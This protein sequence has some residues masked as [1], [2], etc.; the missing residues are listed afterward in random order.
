MSSQMKYVHS[1]HH[2]TPYPWPNSSLQDGRFVYMQTLIDW[3]ER[4]LVETSN[5][6]PKKTR[7]RI[8]S[9]VDLSG[10]EA[11]ER[12]M[13]GDSTG[14]TNG[15]PRSA[16]GK[17]AFPLEVEKPSDTEIQEA[18]SGVPEVDMD[19]PSS[20]PSHRND[21]RS[22]SFSGSIGKIDALRCSLSNKKI[23]CVHLVLNPMKGSDMRYI[24]KVSYL[25]LPTRCTSR[26]PISKCSVN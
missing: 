18:L 16:H 26:E 8:D 13:N 2:A 23:R 6:S 19:P 15:K 11:E 1:L 9:P 3:I 21:D 22:L 20:E 10:G 25:W 14:E 4:G 7:I 17:A 5:C 24:S 12:Y